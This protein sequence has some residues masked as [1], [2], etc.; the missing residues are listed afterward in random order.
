VYRSTERP[1]SRQGRTQ[2]RILEKRTYSQWM[3]TEHPKHKGGC[4]DSDGSSFLSIPSP[5]IYYI[6]PLGRS[7]PSTPCTQQLARNMSVFNA[8]RLLGKTV[9]IT[10]ASSGIGAV[11]LSQYISLEQLI[12]PRQRRQRFFSQ[13]QV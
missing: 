13:K 4:D 12:R 1:R 8:S 2:V 9:L 11:R 10:G 5:I 6:L 3:M 7:L